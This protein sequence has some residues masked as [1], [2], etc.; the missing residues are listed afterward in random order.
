MP[1]Q[2]NKIL[3]SDGK[4]IQSKYVRVFPTSFRG[5]YT[6]GASTTQQ[7]YTFD[8]E[9]RLT[10]EFNL[11]SLPGNKVG[12]D[13]YLISYG[14]E[15]TG[16][17]RYV[18]KFVIGG[19]Y[20]E[21]FS[22]NDFKNEL[23]EKYF[24]IKT[25]S[26]QLAN[27]VGDADNG[28][29]EARYTE[30]LIPITANTADQNQMLDEEVE[31]SNPV[32]YAFLGLGVTDSTDTE[33]ASYSLGPIFVDGK[34]N[35]SLTKP[36]LL[37][38]SA[39]NSITNIVN[40][41][42]NNGIQSSDNNTVVHENSIAYG[43]GLSTTTT[44]QAVF[45][46]FNGAESG[47]LIVGIGTS[48]TDK[49]SGLIVNSNITTINDN[50]KVNNSI[51]VN[52]TTFSAES[53]TISSTNIT[54]N[55]ESLTVSGPTTIDGNA[56]V[57]GTTE[58]N[59]DITITGIT[60]IIG[61][62]T[63]T[64]NTTLTNGTLTVNGKTIIKSSLEA[65]KLLASSGELTLSSTTA[66]N[67]SGAIKY[68]RGSGTASTILQA[69]S[70]NLTLYGGTTTSQASIYLG[71][72]SITISIGSG[73]WLFN[74]NGDFECTRGVI[75]G[76]L[77]S[78]S[79]TSTNS[80][81][82]ITISYDENNKFKIYGI[83]TSSTGKSAELVTN[84]TLS[85]YIPIKIQAIANKGSRTTSTTFTAIDENGWT[86]TTSLNVDTFKL[87]N[88]LTDSNGTTLLSISTNS[89]GRLTFPESIK[90]NKTITA[91]DFNA[92][93]D[94]RLKENIMPFNYNK[95]I[96]HL[97]VYKYNF[98]GDT[99]I[100]IGCL[101]QELRELYPELVTEQEDGY[102]SI[103]ETKL[104][105]LLLEEVKKLKQEIEELK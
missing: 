16:N 55:T 74:S 29:D 98:I 30:R 100:Q 9:A 93:S 51:S 83:T 48:N 13:N 102:L 73:Q 23:I 90:C 101:A 32:E 38:G 52:G 47:Q 72:S 35:L 95:S 67:S 88:K 103:K 71:T 82:N 14:Q 69:A 18:L 5:T 54:L 66:S 26:V 76:K 99:K 77:Y 33:N 68:K 94:V 57:T 34:I 70:D 21:I 60:S 19:Y 86:S 22:P 44:N 27:S 104:V 7:Q 87:I 6:G 63:I 11:R 49:K 10:T 80:Q 8:P 3:T 53:S 78:N 17:T 56:T 84:T 40:I 46:Q 15:N 12:K 2:Q 41:E 81:A 91:K 20:F 105:Y 75:D 31:D 37:S 36:K 50:L 24:Y 65:T 97:P 89:I 61:D 79:I 64:G 43:K 4:Y 1:E 42:S 58:I 45:G 96:L 59:G 62:T 25:T 85:K 92:D 28:I 39:A